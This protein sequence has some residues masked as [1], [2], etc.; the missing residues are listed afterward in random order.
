MQV[1]KCA[2]LEKDQQLGKEK[3]LPASGLSI[4]SQGRESV[5]HLRSQPAQPRRH[6]QSLFAPRLSHQ[7]ASSFSRATV[8]ILTPVHTST[9]SSHCAFW[10]PRGAIPCS[11]SWWEPFSLLQVA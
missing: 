2:V 7:G 9:H 4:R 10:S 3:R 5:L 1:A 6:E 8:S 11:L